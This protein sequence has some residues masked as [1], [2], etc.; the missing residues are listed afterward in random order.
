MATKSLHE[1]VTA[2]EET[3][4]GLQNLPN[5]LA[6]FRRE[7]NARFGQVERRISEESEQ[8][9]ARMRM[10]HEELINRIRIGREGR[11]GGEPGAPRQPRRRPK[12]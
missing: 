3:V 10:L 12:R 6:E 4:A 2:L 9:Y 1:R 11:D 7:T 5:D 8:L